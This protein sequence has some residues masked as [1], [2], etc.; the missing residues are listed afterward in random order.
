MR[1][2][3]FGILKFVVLGVIF[4][5]VIGFVTMSLWNWLVPDL[6]HGPQITFW[7]ALGILLLGKLLFGWHGHQRGGG[8][9]GAPWG[10]K[11]RMRR[12]MENMTPEERERMRAKFRQH[13]GDRA[14]FW[15][16]WDE[17]SFRR[18]GQEATAPP[19]PSEMK[20]PGE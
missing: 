3:P 11:E 18:P 2:R 5:G 4:I 7:Q 19:P 20:P 6:F 17:T 13:C 15:K 8:W 16:E 14:G 9:K 1:R 12:R 10:W